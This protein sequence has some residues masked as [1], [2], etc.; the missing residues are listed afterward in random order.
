MRLKARALLSGDRDKA[1]FGALLLFTVFRGAASHGA[2]SF[3]FG[4]CV[5]LGFLHNVVFSFQYDF[6]GVAERQTAYRNAETRISAHRDAT[7]HL[8][9]YIE[10]P[11]RVT[12]GSGLC[13]RGGRK[14]SEKRKCLRKEM[15]IRCAR[16][17]KVKNGNAMREAM[18]RVRND[19]AENG[20]VSEKQ[21]PVHGMKNRNARKR[22]RAACGIKKRKRKTPRGRDGRYEDHGAHCVPWH[23]ARFPSVRFSFSALLFC[24]FFPFCFAFSALLSFPFFSLFPFRAFRKNI[25]GFSFAF[26]DA[27]SFYACSFAFLLSALRFPPSSCPPGPLSGSMKKTPRM[28]SLCCSAPGALFTPISYHAFLCL[29]VQAVPYSAFHRHTSPLSADFLSMLF[30]RSLVFRRTGQEHGRELRFF[31]PVRYFLMR[32]GYA[33]GR[34]GRTPAVPARPEA[35]FRKQRNYLR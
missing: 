25:R 23:A 20:N 4:G 31:F 26:R 19:G 2:Y 3:G 11:I 35:S 8:H 10:I 18:R 32:W 16:N 12:Q 29:Q 13:R 1:G 6:P 7:V 24:R 14:R 5:F 33:K 22:Q 34:P 17:E 30:M 27:A 9:R 15:E 28:R 21:N